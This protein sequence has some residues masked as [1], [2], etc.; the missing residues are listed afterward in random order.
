MLIFRIVV[1]EHLDQLQY[2]DP[3]SY[4]APHSLGRERHAHMGTKD[5]S[6]TVTGRKE[7]TSIV[8]SSGSRTLEQGS[9][10]SG[11]SSDSA[12][13][14]KS[15]TAEQW[16]EERINKGSVLR[17]RL[18]PRSEAL[19]DQYPWTVNHTSTHPEEV[20]H[21][22][23]VKVHK[24][25]STTLFSI[26][27][28]FAHS[29]RLNVMFPIKGNLLSQSDPELSSLIPH[30]PSPPF[31]FDVLCHHVIFNRSL[32]RPYFPADTK[33]VAIVR[34][35]RRQLWSAFYFYRYVFHK[36]YLRPINSFE[37]FIHKQSTIE[38]LSVYESM[39]NNR[40]S[41]DMG[42][43]P[44]RLNDPSY[45]S[46]FIKHLDDVFELVLI[47][48]RF[49]ESVLLLK[50][51]FSW[52][53]KDVV[54]RAL[55][56]RRK[57]IH[58]EELSPDAENKSQQFQRF[59]VAVYKHFLKVFDQKVAEEGQD[60][61][62]ELIYYLAIQ[63]RIKQ[64]CSKTNMSGFELVIPSSR[65]DKQFSIHHSECPILTLREVGL[66]VWSKAVQMA[67]LEK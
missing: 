22:V 40:M 17:R 19:A 10:P 11:L 31:L 54:Y 66:N 57:S 29:R 16:V 55:N 61:T 2:S 59:D 8:I 65:W 1:Q 27:I 35:P 30:P 13:P 3:L 43:D 28:R 53:M 58:F 23:F 5:T 62:E 49:D 20:R 12:E 36:K 6:S 24:A 52:T 4:E 26:F 18:W 41:V 63:N 46:S 34:D 51:R 38:P 44:H 15:T 42:L 33:H 39:T 50:R 7:K 37:E 45:V 60:F 21:V 14:S 32:L 67:R 9:G 25:A 48:D 64:F 47:A 56:T